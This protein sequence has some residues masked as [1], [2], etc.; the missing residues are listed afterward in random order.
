MLHLSIL[1]LKMLVEHCKFLLSFP[2]KYRKVNSEQLNI[3]GLSTYRSSIFLFKFSSIV[4]TVCLSYLGKRKMIM[5]SFTAKTPL[6]DVQGADSSLP[7]FIQIHLSLELKEKLR[8]IA[9]WTVRK[10]VEMCIFYVIYDMLT[11]SLSVAE[12]PMHEHSP[13]YI[14]TRSHAISI[15]SGNAGTK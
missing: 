12:C 7:D 6:S 3:W 4:Y 8:K 15:T 10:N 5:L 1:Q 11:H 14:P 13:V 2:F 9:R